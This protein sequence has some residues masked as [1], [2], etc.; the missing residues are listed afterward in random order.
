MLYFVSRIK[1]FI[2]NLIC[3]LSIS[4]IVKM[5][6]HRQYHD[7][8]YTYIPTYTSTNINMCVCVDYIL[9]KLNDISIMFEYVTTYIKIIYLR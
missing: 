9:I 3:C 8:N 4:S 2:I 6:A 5:F 1:N 7:S